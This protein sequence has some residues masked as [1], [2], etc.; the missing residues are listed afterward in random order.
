MAE[1]QPKKAENGAEEV[2]HHYVS[3][4][5]QREKK[6]RQTS[7]NMQPPMTP[8]ID[9]VFQLLLFFLLTCQFRVQEGQIKANLPNIAGPQMAPEIPVEPLRIN[10]TPQG[11]DNEG[12][13]I[14]I[15]GNRSPSGMAE[16]YGML[17]ELQDS[18]GP[19]RPVIIKPLENVR[20]GHVVDAFNQAI[21]ARYTNVGLAPAGA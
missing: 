18:G 8:M 13:V 7:P 6:A 5:K 12:V 21:R 11:S 10:L 19:D 4:R 17:R 2:V 16:L 9:C 20:W 14:D 1:D 15:V 3:D